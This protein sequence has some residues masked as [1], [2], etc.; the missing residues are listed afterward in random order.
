[1]ENIYINKNKKEVSLHVNSVRSFL[2]K[3]GYKIGC[4]GDNGRISGMSN[5]FGGN[6]EVKENFVGLDVKHEVAQ[7]DG[8]KV[9]RTIITNKSNVL[10]RIWNDESYGKWILRN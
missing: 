6:L 8:Y 1:M 10:V 4:W 7:R 5:F 3:I 2:K 9:F